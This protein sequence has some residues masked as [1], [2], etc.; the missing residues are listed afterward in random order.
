MTADEF[1]F[2]RY[3]NAKTN[4]FS[5]WV[6]FQDKRNYHL[7]QKGRKEFIKFFSEQLGPLGDRW[8]YEKTTSTFCIKL[9]NESD[10]TMMTLRYAN[11]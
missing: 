9:N 6:I 10:A 11:K 7:G 2:I 1:K 4:R 5:F 3:M 8:E